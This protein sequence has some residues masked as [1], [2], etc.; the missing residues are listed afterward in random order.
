[1]DEVIE[2]MS[3]LNL[4]KN[5]SPLLK[6]HNINGIVLK[7]MTK[8]DWN[9]IGINVFGDVRTLLTVVKNIQ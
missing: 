5:Y 9:T 8:E 7:T 4:S 3:R 6:E 2:W 1:V